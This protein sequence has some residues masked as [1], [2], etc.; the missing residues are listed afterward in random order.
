MPGLGPE[1]RS[2]TTTLVSKPEA[3]EKMVHFELT[4]ALTFPE[5]EKESEKSK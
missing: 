2:I 5:K 1:G 4:S 3:Y